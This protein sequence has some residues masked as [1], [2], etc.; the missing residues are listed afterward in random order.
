MEMVN[1]HVH[2]VHQHVAARTTHRQ[3]VEYGH[4][5]RQTVAEET[6]WFDRT[7]QKVV[8]VEIDELLRQALYPV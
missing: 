4:I 8:I 5:A 7:K 1:Y 3:C 6:F 2:V